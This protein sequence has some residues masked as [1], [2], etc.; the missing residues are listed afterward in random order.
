MTHGRE[1]GHGR[2]Q[3]KVGPGGNMDGNENEAPPFYR[4]VGE[5]KGPGQLEGQ[6]FPLLRNYCCSVFQLQNHQKFDLGK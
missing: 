6:I 4:A 5:P 1:A 2:A 3:S